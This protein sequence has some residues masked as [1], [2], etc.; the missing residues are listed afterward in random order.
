MPPDPV[1][2]D[3]LVRKLQAEAGDALRSVTRYGETD[4]EMIYLRENVEAI[5]TE[6]EFDEI[7]E[8][9]RLEGWGRDTLEELFNAGML[10]CSI[11]GFEE[12]MM[13]HFVSN[14]FEGAL[15]TYDRGA[16]VET[17]Q[18]IEACKSEFEE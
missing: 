6:A 12:A 10:E 14:G 8:D 7:F 15:V 1:D 5:Y 9:L 17:E 13:F 18:F 3:R 4:Y 11:Y 16:D 2:D